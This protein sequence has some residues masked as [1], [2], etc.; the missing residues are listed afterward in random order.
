MEYPEMISTLITGLISAGITAFA[1]KKKADLDKA[2]ETRTEVQ[3][4]LQANARFREEIRLDLDKAKTEIESLRS[5]LRSK[6]QLITTLQGQ[7]H[8]L[9]M[10]IIYLTSAKSKKKV[11]LPVE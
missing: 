10:Q 8:D 7:V 11:V 6:D 3:D 1:M 2:V 9:S 5:E 4:I